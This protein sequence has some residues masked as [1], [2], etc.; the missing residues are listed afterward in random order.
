M[1]CR[2]LQYWTWKNKGAEIRFGDLQHLQLPIGAI[3]FGVHPLLY[4]SLSLRLSSLAWG[5][6][7][8][9][10]KLPGLYFGVTA[11][12]HVWTEVDADSRSRSHKSDVI[13]DIFQAQVARA[14]RPGIGSLSP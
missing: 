12:R 1:R 4:A 2:G 9:N 6:Q 8:T 14:E 3:S 7:Y 10:S 11:M 5:K 13:L